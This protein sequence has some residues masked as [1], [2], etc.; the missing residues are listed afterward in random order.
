MSWKKE[1]YEFL[2]KTEEGTAI[3]ETV[4]S[5]FKEYDDT[6]AKLRLANKEIEE[7]KLSVE[8]A[9][10]IKTDS[11]KH[12]EKNTTLEQKIAE[13][14]GI[15]EKM[16]SDKAEADKRI[17]EA[18]ADKRIQRIKSETSDDLKKAFGSL[19]GNLLV[20]NY[21]NNGSLTYSTEDQL[22]FTH[23]GKVYTGKEQVMEAIRTVHKEDIKGS[24][25]AGTVGGSKGSAGVV[26]TSNMSAKEN[27][28]AFAQT[29]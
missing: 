29:L 23:E 26:D 24:D 20:D 12:V 14:T 19:T 25:G 6:E 1:L 13:L 28:L 21:I 18:E 5:G 3:I 4:K 2:E 8:E 22:M 15:V 17:A 10:K 16:N 7:L 27:F 9:E 11:N